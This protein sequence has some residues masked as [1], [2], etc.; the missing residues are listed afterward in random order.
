MLTCSLVEID[1][2]FSIFRK[3]RHQ[4]PCVPDAGHSQLTERVQGGRG[5]WAAP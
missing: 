3:A 1:M 4:V 5:A 2:P